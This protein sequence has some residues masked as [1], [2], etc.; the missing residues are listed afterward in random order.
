MQ[1][2]STS[3]WLQVKVGKWT[4]NLYQAMLTPGPSQGK[5]SQF[6]PHS[7]LGWCNHSGHSLLPTGQLV[8]HTHMRPTVTVKQH[9]CQYSVYI[10]VKML[11]SSQRDHH[12]NL[13]IL[14]THYFYPFF[15]SF[16]SSTHSPS[17][18]YRLY[19]IEHF[20]YKIYKWE[21]NKKSQKN[22]SINVHLAE[23]HSS[24]C[25]SQRI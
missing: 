23:G 6:N 7:T 16:F 18:L 17:F 3:T 22:D 11:L 9:Q 25:K 2:L 10:W 24:I 1:I 5:A 14:K 15:Y 8:T 12:V 20:R 21:M 13:Y 4:E 19:S